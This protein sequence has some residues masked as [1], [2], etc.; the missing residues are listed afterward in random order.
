M[1]KVLKFI[2]MY[3]FVIPFAFTGFGIYPLLVFYVSEFWILFWILL[4]VQIFLLL[5]MFYQCHQE[6]KRNKRLNTIK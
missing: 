3:F 6:V 1:N 4:S 5:R 2:W